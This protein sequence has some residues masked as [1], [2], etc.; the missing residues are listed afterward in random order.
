MCQLSP[1]PFSR[2]INWVH[3]VNFNQKLLT[4]MLLVLRDV[5]DTDVDKFFN[6]ISICLFIFPFFPSLFPLFFFFYCG[7]WGFLFMYIS[8]KL[9]LWLPLNIVNLFFKNNLKCNEI[10][11][12]II[13]AYFHKNNFFCK[14]YL[15]TWSIVNLIVISEMS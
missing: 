8:Y 15:F 2:L 4:W 1:I 3:R 11:Y 13:Y 14:I 6:I 7:R 12:I 10:R 5:I 9:K